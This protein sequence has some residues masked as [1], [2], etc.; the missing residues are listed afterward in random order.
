[1]AL[2][3]VILA[4]YGLFEPAHEIGG[5][6][7]KLIKPRNHEIPFPKEAYKDRSPLNPV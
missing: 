3:G 4:A 7:K 6:R 2:R 1:M 5:G